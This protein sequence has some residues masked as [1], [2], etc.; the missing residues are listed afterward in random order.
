MAKINVTA[1]HDYTDSVWDVWLEED[2]MRPTHMRVKANS[3]Y[4]AIVETCE[5]LGMSRRVAEKI[6]RDA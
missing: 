4:D 5:E 6:A 3:R 2:G 1:R